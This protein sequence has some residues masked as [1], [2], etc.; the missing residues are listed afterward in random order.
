[1]PTQGTHLVGALD[2]SAQLRQSPFRKDQLHG[3][4]DDLTPL[5]SCNL[6]P[7]R[8]AALL[9][10][11]VGAAGRASLEQAIISYG[12]IPDGPLPAELLAGLDAP[13]TPAEYRPLLALCRLLADSLAPSPLAG[14]AAAPALLVSLERLFERHVIRAVSEAFGPSA[15]AQTTHTL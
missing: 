11:L 1:T 8:L 7:R 10:P 15:Q 5:L 12:R 2:L 9:S 4:L 13:D 3:R 6:V 14:Q